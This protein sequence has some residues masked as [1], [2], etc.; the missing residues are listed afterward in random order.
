MNELEY[1][2]KLN[3]NTIVCYCIATAFALCSFVIDLPKN[4][5]LAVTY[6]LIISS[7]FVVA[8]SCSLVRYHKNPASKRIKLFVTGGYLIC[9]FCLSCGSDNPANYVYIFPM[10]CILLVYCSVRLIGVACIIAIGFNV[11]SIFLHGFGIQPV[12]SS[13]F[14]HMFTQLSSI[15]LSAALC[16][17]SV[18]LLSIKDEIFTDALDVKYEDSLTGLK[19][20]R[21]IDD[22]RASRFDLRRNQRLCI[23]FIDIDDFKHFNTMYGHTVGD[24]VLKN[25]A[26]TFMK[27]IADIPHTYAIR[28]G[29][30]EFL[31]ISRTLKASTFESL[32][33][34][35]RTD[36]SETQYP[37]LHMDARVTISVGIS[38]KE[39]DSSMRSFQELYDAADMRNHIAKTSGKNLIIIEGRIEPE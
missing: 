30:D 25:I 9:Y 14:G 27:N 16:N 12:L 18:H 32:I 11:I 17:R 8:L 5:Y 36:I 19:N 39:V 1:M 7:S 2:K 6:V 34:K 15:G 28:N 22:S 10:F 4:N 38:S 21:F 35:C 13:N 24:L 31:I 29:G 26:M 37:F 23:A 33:D 3:I 20:V